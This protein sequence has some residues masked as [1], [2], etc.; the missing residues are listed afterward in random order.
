[1]TAYACRFAND[2]VVIAADTAIYVPDRPPVKPQVIGY[3]SKVYPLAF[4]HAK[5]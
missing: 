3:T 5:R 2:R 1:M 4:L